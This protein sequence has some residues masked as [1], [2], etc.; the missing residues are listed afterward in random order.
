MPPAQ[1]HS[2]LGPSRPQ[3]IYSVP[4]FM[5]A[6]EQAN[7]DRIR[8][9]LQTPSGTGRPPLDRDPMIKLYLASRSRRTEV[10]REMTPLLEQLEN[11]SHDLA[12]L[13]GFDQIPSRSTLRTVFLE[14]DGLKKEVRLTQADIV[15][16]L[17]GKNGKPKRDT[18]GKPRQITKGRVIK[19]KRKRRRNPKK[20]NAYRKMRLTCAMGVFQFEERIP[21]E[22]AAEAFIVDARWPD[23]VVRCPNPNCGS[24]DVVE[25]RRRKHRT[26]RCL[27]CERRFHALTHTTLKGVHGSWRALLLAVYCS[28]QFPYQSALSL[29]CALKT[30]GRTRNHRTSLRLLH[31]IFEA[32][33]VDLL[34][35][36][37]DFQTDDT[38]IGNVDGIP[39]TVLGCVSEETGRVVAEVIVGEVELANSTPFIEKATD[40]NARMMS[41]ESNK[42]PWG[43]RTRLTVNHKKK[44]YVRWYEAH[45]KL[46]TSNSMESF[47]AA[48]KLFLHMHRSLTLR[49]LYLYVA[50]AA[51][52]IGNLSVPTVDQMKAVIRNAHVAWLRP[53]KEIP[54]EL[55]D[56]QMEIQAYKGPAKPKPARKTRRPLNV[57]TPL[58]EAKPGTKDLAD[59]A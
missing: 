46:A 4:T 26:W 14:L 59:A 24:D 17:K 27:Q 22:K 20:A 25:V 57:Q 8:E 13:C 16:L 18:K 55:L 3:L 49:H 45:H 32:L 38:L 28:L 47:W 42:L 23:G 52:H 19:D 53:A 40:K 15:R 29:A 54:E 7:L 31:R 39:V 11:G 36:T 56:F 34:P 9:H 43:I 6:A 10:P 12:T 21:D 33:E 41:D 50:A 2:T 37:G 35:I 44:K 5:E 51:W 1:G 48:L 58:P 30:D